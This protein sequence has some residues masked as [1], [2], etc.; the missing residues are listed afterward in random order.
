MDESAARA[1]RLLGRFRKVMDRCAVST[2]K[3]TY[4]PYGP[5]GMADCAL[6]TLP[7]LDC[8]GDFAAIYA[9]FEADGSIRLSDDGAIEGDVLNGWIAP[10]KTVEEVLRQYQ[11]ERGAD[12]EL[13]C[14]AIDEEEFPWKLM[15][16]AMC[17]G[18]LS[19]LSN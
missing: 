6:F 5:T 11:V 16:M 10:M 1:K 13:T 14:T 18:A 12:G 19:R 15:S 8:R 3:R 9:W 2:F 4:P 7:F 17:M